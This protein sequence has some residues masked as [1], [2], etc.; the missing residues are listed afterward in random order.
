MLHGEGVSKREM[1]KIELKAGGIPC[2]S[3]DGLRSYDQELKTICCELYMRFKQ[4]SNVP[5]QQVVNCPR[6][7]ALQKR[8]QD[9]QNARALAAQETS[10]RLAAFRR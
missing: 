5:L 10:E 7:K 6:Y 1:Q 9:Q 8:F 2:G 4:K 3:C